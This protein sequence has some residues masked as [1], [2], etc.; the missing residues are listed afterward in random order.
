MP[1]RW[2]PS[3]LMHG[4]PG[5]PWRWQ[6]RSRGGPRS[7]APFHLADR[8]EMALA[9]RL[10]FQ[11]PMLRLAAGTS[12]DGGIG[13]RGGRRGRGCRRRAPCFATGSAWRKRR[14]GGSRRKAWPR[15]PSSRPRA[16]PWAGCNGNG[17][18]V[19]RGGRQGGA[20]VVAT[21]ARP[22]AGCLGKR[23][24]A[25]KWSHAGSR[26]RA[27]SRLPP[28]RPIKIYEAASRGRPLR[29]P[30]AARKTHS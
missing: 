12:R 5:R 29:R 3:N 23:G 14:Q 2:R 10:L 13:D 17:S 1:V 8:H 7:C 16:L 24:V 20:R 21:P 27:G 25:G 28:S 18:I 22:R 15:L 11:G 6:R 9:S 4:R 26:G 30:L 19:A